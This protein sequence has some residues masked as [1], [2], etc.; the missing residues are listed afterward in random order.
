MLQTG[1]RQL[2][3]KPSNV[4]PELLDL[5]FLS[6]EEEEAILKVLQRDENL[7]KNDTGRLR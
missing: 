7:R 2:A 4:F 1:E 3:M 5:S 6:A